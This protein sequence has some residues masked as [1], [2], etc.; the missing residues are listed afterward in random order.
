M[1]IGRDLTPSS[2]PVVGDLTNLKPEFHRTL[3]GII[4]ETGIKY[5]YIYIT[6]FLKCHWY[7]QSNEI[8]QLKYSLNYS[9]INNLF[10]H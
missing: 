10:M 5:K 1:F 2:A 4:K 7:S 6:D 9:F 3:R 8:E